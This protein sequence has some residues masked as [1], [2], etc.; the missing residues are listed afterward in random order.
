M[1]HLLVLDK[2]EDRTLRQKLLDQIGKD[3]VFQN[4]TLTVIAFHAMKTITVKV[5]FWKTVSFPIQ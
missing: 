5:K 1:R 2:F 4:L 3:T